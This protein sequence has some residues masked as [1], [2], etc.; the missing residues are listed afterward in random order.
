LSAPA[1]VIDVLVIFDQ[2]SFGASGSRSSDAGSLVSNA[3]LSLQNT[4]LSGHSFNLKYAHT[5]TPVGFNSATTPNSQA[6]V[7][8]AY[9][10]PEVD[11]LRDQHA[12]DVV[13]MIVEHTEPHPTGEVCGRAQRPATISVYNQDTY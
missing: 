4:G 5:A 6:A 11:Q 8:F 10:S 1:A 7:D 13:V 3:N 9:V 12:A 2:A